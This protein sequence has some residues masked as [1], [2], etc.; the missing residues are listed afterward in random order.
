MEYVHALVLSDT[1]GNKSAIDAV[2]QECGAV[3]YIFHLGDNS[4]DARYIDEK[5]RAKVVFV[6]GNCDMGDVGN[7]VDEIVL[8]GQKILLTHGHLFK[9]KYSYDRLYYKG[10]EAEAKAALFGHTHKPFCE[11]RDGLWL[12]N[13]GSAGDSFDG[14][15]HY[16]TL[17]IGE[18]GVVPKLRTL[19]GGSV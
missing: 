3:D 16:A 15:V 2:L 6:K 19:A 12:V 9:V 8:K 11:Y 10:L 7:E 1:H 4:S 18:M 13:P 14:V 5:T 17:L